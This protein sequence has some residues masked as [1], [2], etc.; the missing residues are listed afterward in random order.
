MHAGLL[1][2][3]ASVESDVSEH[4]PYDFRAPGFIPDESNS[5]IITQAD[6]RTRCGAELAADAEEM[7]AV[8]RE[9]VPELGDTEMIVHDGDLYMVG[10]LVRRL[11]SQPPP[12]PSG[13]PEDG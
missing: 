2:A 6:G 9:E 4:D 7:M 11:G 5:L 13:S 10:D 12:V 1:P 8:I 3:G